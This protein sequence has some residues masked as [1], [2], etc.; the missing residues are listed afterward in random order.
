MGAEK[1]RDSSLG[2]RYIDL[3]VI[4]A[5]KSAEVQFALFLAITAIDRYCRAIIDLVALI[6]ERFSAMQTL[7]IQLDHFRTAS[8]ACGCFKSLLML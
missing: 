6:H 7:D 1:P 3:D 8:L 4:T 5:V 2:T